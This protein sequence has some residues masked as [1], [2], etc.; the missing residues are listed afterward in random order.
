MFDDEINTAIENDGWADDSI[1]DY[2][3]LRVVDGDIS[4]VPLHQVA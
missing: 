2:N 1:M 3:T 4:Y